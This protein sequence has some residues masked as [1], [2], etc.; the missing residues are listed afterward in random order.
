MMKFHYGFD[1]ND[2]EVILHKAIANMH[3]ND[4]IVNG[5]LYLTNQRLFFVGYVP[6]SRTRMSCEISL[7]HVKEVIPEKT[8]HLFNNVIRVVNLREE[9]FKFI[10]DGQKEWLDQIGRQLRALE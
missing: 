8:F 3:D 5:A 1:I 2:N 7:Y 6:N 4:L 10:V 9:Q